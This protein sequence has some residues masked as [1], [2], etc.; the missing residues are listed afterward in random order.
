[1]AG[2]LY[3]VATPLGNLE[4][5]SP[6]ARR[7][8]ASVAVIAAED[9]RHT[10][11]LLSHFDIHTALTSYYDQVERERAPQ[12]VER[13]K[14]G[15]DVA[16]V[17]DAGTPGIADP[18]YR[19][20]R[21]AIEAGVTV[22]PVPGA[23]AVVA[24]L[25]VAGLPTDR[26][27]FEGFVPSRGGER[28]RFYESLAGE[29][30]TVVCFESGHRLLDSLADLAKALGEREIVVARELTKAFEELLRGPVSEV[31]ARLEAGVVRGEV[32]L[33]LAPSPEPRQAP[34]EEVRAALARLRRDGVG[35]KQ[36]AKAVAKE[37]GRHARDVYRIGLELEGETKR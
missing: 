24:A 25:S 29:R 17:S 16:L 5:L 2:T 36:A 28:R 6:R 14:R 13:L 22:V 9:T 27:C 35:L 7:V 21:A 15:D 32:T 20:V 23:S 10:R 1:M 26:F 12:L 30:R 8:L 19:L 37:T 18:G 34:L 3:V 33:L 31:R 4:D 11:K